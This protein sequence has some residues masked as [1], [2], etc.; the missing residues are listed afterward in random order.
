MSW[1][2]KILFSFKYS[3]FHEKLNIQYY[4][5]GLF[6]ACFHR[7]CFDRAHFDLLALILRAVS[8]NLQYEFVK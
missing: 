7:L 4:G 2:S 1:E 3:F 5:D 6:F 8:Q